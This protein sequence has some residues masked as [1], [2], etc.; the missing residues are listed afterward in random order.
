VEILVDLFHTQASGDGVAGNGGAVDSE[1]V[2]ERPR[3]E[4]GGSKADEERSDSDDR[5]STGSTSA[6]PQ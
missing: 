2:M 6:A 4:S 5:F 1:S 3:G